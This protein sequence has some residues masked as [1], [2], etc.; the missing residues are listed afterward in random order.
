MLL[1]FTKIGLNK[2]LPYYIL[3]SIKPKNLRKM[4][5]QQYKKILQTPEKEC[6]IQFLNL[7]WSFYKY[8]EEQF[9]C[10]IGVSH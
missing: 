10:S 2:F 8:D 3:E 7:V 6:V 1:F 5:Q 4:I 9:K